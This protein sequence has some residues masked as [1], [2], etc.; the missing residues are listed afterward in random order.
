[1][2]RFLRSISFFVA[3]LFLASCSNTHSASAK[4]SIPQASSVAPA[5]VAPHPQKIALLLPLSGKLSPYANAIR[6]GYTTAAEEQKMRGGYSPEITV[7]DTTGK[8]VIDTYH[9]AV[10]Q[11][12]NLIVGPLNKG[13]VAVLNDDHALTTPVL[14]LNATDN[15][16]HVNDKVFQFALSPTDEA[17]QAAIKAMSDHHHAAI[18]LAPNNAWG[19]RLANAFTAQWKTMGGNIVATEYYDGMTTLSRKISSVLGINEGYQNDH[20]VASMLRERVRYIPARRQDFDS[21]FMVATPVMAKEIEPLLHFYF[22][23]NI[24]IYTTSQINTASAMND[25]DLDGIQFCDMPW[26]L[27]PNDMPNN[28]RASQQHIQQ[29]WPQNYGS[30]S[31]FYA[32]GVD[33]FTLSTELSTLPTHAPGQSGATGALYLA[34]NHH[35]N[36][37]LMWAKFVNGSPQLIR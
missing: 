34:P 33:A 1:M 25:R 31:K 17:E 9:A 14:A 24:P 23:G 15:N 20:A 2:K 29:T 11:G 5:A 35:I 10:A 3:T 28:V 26:V 22:A 30:L 37:T 4:L 19:H 36:R 18:I 27:A 6:N 13:D 21:I 16:V 8:N 12:A 32:M 7:I